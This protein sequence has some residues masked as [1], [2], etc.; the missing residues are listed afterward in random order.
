QHQSL[1]QN[2]AVCIPHMAQRGKTRG[3]NIANHRMRD[4]K[5][6]GSGNPDYANARDYISDTPYFIPEDQID[7]LNGDPTRLLSPFANQIFGAPPS[8]DQRLGISY[9]ISNLFEAKVWNKKD[10]TSQNVKLFQNIG[11]SG[12]YDFTRDTLKW[13]NVRMSGGTQ[14]FKGVTRVN[15]TASFDPYITRYDA[16]TDR[17]RRIN[18]THLSEGRFPLALE[19]LSSS[20]STNLT[21][22][23][24]R[25]LF[26]GAEEEV[27]EDINEERRKRREEEETIFEETDILSLFERFSIRHTYRFRFRREFDEEE[28]DVD[29]RGRP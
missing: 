7:P 28:P 23:K 2:R 18:T 20:I 11:V 13:S 22:Q 26:Q 19:Q 17:F 24:I 14:F 10:S 12:S 5:G 15:V 1:I 9:S 25:E 21:V 3:R 8:A 16:A 29:D 27:V 4:V 6:C